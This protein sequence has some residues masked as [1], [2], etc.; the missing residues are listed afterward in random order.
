MI[1]K[2]KRI[3]NLN[4]HL[5]MIPNGSQVVVGISDS[6]R[7]VDIYRQVGF[8]S[9]LNVGDVIL[10]SAGLGPVSHYNAEGKQLVLKDQPMETAYRVVEWH[11]IEWHGEDRVEQSDFVDVPY[12]RYPRRFLPPPSVEFRVG[13]S[14]DGDKIVYSSP[15]SYTEENKELLRHTIN[16]YLEIFGECSLFSENLEVMMKGSVRRL[17]WTILPPGKMPWEQLRRH[18]DSMIKQA[19]GG[20]QPVIA[21]RLET[22]NQY[23]PDFTA[24]GRAGFEGYVIFGFSERNLYVCESRYTGNATYV[25]GKAWETLSQMTKADILS[26]SLQEARLIHREGWEKQLCRVMR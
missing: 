4:K 19:P 16:L 18:L 6:D 20:S 3:R 14:T 17:N 12:E 25:F 24:I 13:I 8:D 9:G 23:G 2:G 1:I 22:V 21:H 15:V 7:F 11:W 26:E 5:A 10:P